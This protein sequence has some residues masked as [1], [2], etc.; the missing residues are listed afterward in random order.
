MAYDKNSFLSGVAVGKQL[1]GW[2]RAQP[3]EPKPRNAVTFEP[4]PE[5]TVAA[6]V[7]GG[8]PG[9]IAITATLEVQ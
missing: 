2:G 8:L 6:T 7:S 3:D 1:K 4:A 9:A 5:Y